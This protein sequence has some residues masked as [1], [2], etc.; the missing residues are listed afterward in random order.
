MLRFCWYRMPVLNISTRKELT[1][2][3]DGGTAGKSFLT[4]VSSVP[5]APAKYSKIAYMSIMDAAN[6][7]TYDLYLEMTREAAAATGVMLDKNVLTLKPNETAKLTASVLP[8]NTTDSERTTSDA[9]IATVKDGAVTALKTGT[10][11]ITAVCGS[12][13][14]MC[15]YGGSTHAGRWR[16]TQQK[17]HN[18]VSGRDSSSLQRA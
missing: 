15:C 3:L 11:T 8:E 12:A 10:A 17:Y 14:G 13:K 7:R 6:D 18:A 4:D 5:F 1:P 9:S 16:R 2:L